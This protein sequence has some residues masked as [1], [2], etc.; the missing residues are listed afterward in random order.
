MTVISFSLLSLFKLIL[1]VRGN[2][3]FD[4]RR[5]GNKSPGRISSLEKNFSLVGLGHQ[6]NMIVGLDDLIA[7]SEMIKDQGVKRCARKAIVRAVIQRLAE[8]RIWVK[9]FKKALM[10][11]Y[12]DLIQELN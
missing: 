3:F 4:C 1:S 5:I 10:C 2:S 7:I 11:F 12:K 6:K 9:V 8:G